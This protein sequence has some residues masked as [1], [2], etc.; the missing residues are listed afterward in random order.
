[1]DPAEG[2]EPTTQTRPKRS[3]AGCLT[4]R[5]RRR[6]F[7]NS[8]KYPKVQ[9]VSEQE[10]TPTEGREKGGD[11]TGE[12]DQDEDVTPIRS[13]PSLLQTERTQG[14]EAQVVNEGIGAAQIASPPTD[15]YEFALHGL[16]ALGAGN[17]VIVDEVVNLSP[18]SAPVTEL[19]RHP[20]RIQDTLNLSQR[21]HPQGETPED[22]PI[23]TPAV[24]DWQLIGASVPPDLEPLSDDFT[25]ELLKQYRY[26]L[27][28]WMDICDLRQSFGCEVLQLSTEVDAIR[29]EILALADASLRWR[30][31]EITQEDAPDIALLA[32]LVRQ[33]GNDTDPIHNALLE[34]LISTRKATTD[35]SKFWQYWEEAVTKETLMGSVLAEAVLRPLALPIFWLAVRLDLSAAIL[36]ASPCRILVP[37]PSPVAQACSAGTDANTV[38]DCVTNAI[39]FCVDALSFSYGGEGQVLDGRYGR[40][41]VEVWNSLVRC[42]EQWYAHRSVEFQP[43]IEL[44]SRDG[45]GS[46]DEFPM[47]V[48]TSG[49]AVLANQLHHFGMVL[50]L[51]NKPR[52]ASATH[53]SSSFMS[54]HWHTHRICGIAINNDRQECW[55]PC[56]LSSY[57]FVARRITHH[58]QHT[59]I[60]N[61]LEDIQKLTGWNVSQHV[62]KLLEDWHMAEGW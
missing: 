51:Q 12:Q 33:R 10:I 17:A 9:F 7:A 50:L 62:N 49:A 56:L 14:P 34:I 55:D 29:F 38:F 44:Y 3:R 8:A 35:L 20:E 41:R 58:S 36:N 1:M 21:L 23:A 37:A 60:H 52:F 47:V 45:T 11:G 32:M 24:R 53:P 22:V 28:P 13:P 30:R 42:S 54:A 15:T 39:A 18:G 6:K 61:S 19:P 27:A 59:A 16:L 31:I 40:N 5:T 46:E 4:C 26:N 48:F 57:L 25:L 2:A 43:I